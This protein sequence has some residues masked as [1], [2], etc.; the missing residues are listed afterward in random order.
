MKAAIKQTLNPPSCPL[1]DSA[2]GA[3]Q[4]IC[5]EFRVTLP[6]LTS[7]GASL[8]AGDPLKSK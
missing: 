5:T 1:I 3:F 8:G 7:L 4:N 6:F 2:G